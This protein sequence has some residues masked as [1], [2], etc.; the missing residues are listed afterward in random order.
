[1]T[2]NEEVEAT[3]KDRTETTPQDVLAALSHYEAAQ[4]AWRGSTIIRENRDA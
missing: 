2:F 4:K 3:R 1:M